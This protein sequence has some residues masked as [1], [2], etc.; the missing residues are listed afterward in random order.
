MQLQFY[1]DWYYRKLKKET[2]AIHGMVVY[3]Y[4]YIPS[5]LNCCVTWIGQQVCQEES[6]RGSNSG[7]MPMYTTHTRVNW[8]R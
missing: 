7:K 5:Y 2:P 4:L 3:I 1:T 6:D 8:L